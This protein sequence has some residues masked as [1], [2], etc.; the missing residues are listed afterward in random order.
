MTG[1]PNFP[2]GRLFAGYRNAWRQEETLEGVRAV[3][4]KT[5]LAPNRGVARRALDFCSFFASS[6]FFSLFEARPDVVVATSPQPLAGFAGWLASRW[7]GC[8]FVLELS[9]LWPASMAGTLR[10]V[11]RGLGWL[12][13][14]AELF[15]Y[16]RANWIAPQ[17][18]AFLADL[19]GRGVP[20]GKM[21]VV[22]NGVELTQYSPR[23]RD[24]G[25]AAQLDLKEDELTVGYYGT[26]GLAHGLE[27]LLDAAA[28]LEGQPIRILIMGPGA[29]REWLIAETTRRGLDRVTI[30]P[31]CAKEEM[32]AYWS[33]LDVA[34]VHLKDAPVF[35][36]VVPSKIYEAMAM[37]LPVLL[38]APEGEA[39]RLLARHEAG[40]HI[41]AGQPER[42]ARQLADWAL[43]R[44]AL[45]SYSRR[46]LSAAPFYSR[47]RQASEFLAVLRRVVEA[48]GVEAPGVEA[49]G[50]EAAL[51]PA[52]REVV[53]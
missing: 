50:V 10:R 15:L 18:E 30:L 20:R 47:E 36:T 1:A 46:A 21:T 49:P 6:L 33:L 42:L 11:P 28:R 27:N 48:P 19:A 29:E 41:A 3:R 24:A 12:L 4:V 31:A 37:A 38:V 5:Y 2:E 22:P 8:P 23:P 43:D 39:S 52:S 25:L 9:D 45:K 35:A 32:P 14:R 53:R 26:L 17:T 51:G 40:V 44:S 16:G 13:E 7:Q 34:I